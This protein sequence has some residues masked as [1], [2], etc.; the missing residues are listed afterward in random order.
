MNKRRPVTGS[1]KVWQAL[2]RGNARARSTPGS[3]TDPLA[4]YT[5]QLRRMLPAVRCDTMMESP[6]EKPRW[7]QGEWTCG[8][9]N[10][11]SKLTSPD[12]ADLTLAWRLAL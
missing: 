6:K 4:P 5:A 11:T 12:A 7:L 9:T 2:P 1:W 8:R 10:R 3:S